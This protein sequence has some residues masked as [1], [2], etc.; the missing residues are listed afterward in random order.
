MPVR[1]C[2]CTHSGGVPAGEAAVD[3]GRRLVVE[4]RAVVQEE[5]PIVRGV[6]AAVLIRRAVGERV[7]VGGRAA[8]DA[9]SASASARRRFLGGR[10]RD[11]AL[12]RTADEP[13]KQ[14]RVTSSQKCHFV[15]G[16]LAATSGK[17][18]DSTIVSEVHAPRVGGMVWLPAKRSASETICGP[19]SP[20]PARTIRGKGRSEWARR[21]SKDA[22][23]AW[24]LCCLARDRFVGSFP[25][26][27]AP[28]IVRGDAWLGGALV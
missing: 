17:V 24:P 5:R 1:S 19:T 21:G 6:R 4:A 8:S 16:T 3:G 2:P 12:R 27:K 11:D 14:Q 23:I 15:D 20:D 13:Q 28:R 10:A 7:G 26:R 9:A 18:I 22:R 25:T